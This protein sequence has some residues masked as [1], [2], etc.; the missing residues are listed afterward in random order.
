[1]SYLGVLRE[2]QSGLFFHGFD[3]G[4]KVTSQYLWG[5]GNAWALL[6]M[7][8]TLELLPKSHRAYPALMTLMEAQLASLVRLQTGSGH[9]H[10]ILNDPRSPLETSL[11]ALY[12][13]GMYL[14]L[15]LNL[16]NEDRRHATQ[17]VADRAFEAALQQAQPDGSFLVSEA[18][19]IG[20]RETYK[21]LGISFYG[22]SQV[23]GVPKSALRSQVLLH[24][25]L[26]PGKP[27]TFPGDTA[28]FYSP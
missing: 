13:V 3:T 16:V 7:I 15:R 20:D 11:S 1:M 2:P 24:R 5:R 22:F 26:P 19:P 14:T 17:A 27:G 9:W 23:C 6:G 4:R 25:C 21:P 12:A 8:E 28:P 18:T 10:T